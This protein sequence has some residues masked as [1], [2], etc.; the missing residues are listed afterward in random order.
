MKHCAKVLTHLQRS[1]KGVF[2]GTFAAWLQKQPFLREGWFCSFS[3]WP[4]NHKHKE[5]TYVKGSTSVVSNTVNLTVD[6]FKS[7]NTLLLAVC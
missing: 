1:F 2:F 7:L 4:M 6:N 5:G 3:H